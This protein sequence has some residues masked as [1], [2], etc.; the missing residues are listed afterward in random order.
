VRTD[1]ASGRGF[2][3]E[4]SDGKGASPHE[5]KMAAARGNAIRALFTPKGTDWIA[6]RFYEGEE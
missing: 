1:R 4:G 6:W 3:D 2:I 5:A